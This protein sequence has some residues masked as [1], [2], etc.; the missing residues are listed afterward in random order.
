M[1]CFFKKYTLHFKKP[2][3]TSRGTLYNKDTYF[4]F[5]KDKNKLAIG[6]CNR[7]IHLSYDDRDNYEEKLTE[8]C[9]QLPEK[10][11]NILPNLKDWPS[12]SF[13]VETVIKDFR[14]G[15]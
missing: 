7:F 9:Q 5:L 13:G 6:E 4:I 15:G 8:V 3:G 12:V 14:N 2:G 10:M 1:Q 11:E